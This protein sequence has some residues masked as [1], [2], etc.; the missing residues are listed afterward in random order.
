MASKH[1]ATVLRQRLRTARV[2]TFDA[3]NTLYKL[4]RGVG[5]LYRD[6]ATAHGIDA[7]LLPSAED[8]KESFKESLKLQRARY[9]N[10]F[11]K[12]VDLGTGASGRQIDATG[13]E[14]E[15]EYIPE[16]WWRM[17]LER[18][19]DGAFYLRD[20][21]TRLTALHGD[22][23]ALI[24][25]LNGEDFFRALYHD[26]FCSDAAWEVLPGAV[27]AVARLARWR[28]RC[29]DGAFDV[30]RVDTHGTETTMRS[31]SS[32]AEAEA[33][34]AEFDAKRHKQGYFVRERPARRLGVLSNN[35]ERLPRVLDALGLKQPFDFVLPSVEARAQKPD[36]L[37]F[38]TAWANAGA[39]SGAVAPHEC[40]HIG[41]DEQNDVRGALDAGVQTVVWVHPE[42]VRRVPNRLMAAH[43]Q[44]KLFIVQ[45]LTQLCQV[46]DGDL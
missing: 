25:Q 27:D 39:G 14:W 20:E 21:H 4:R 7:A 46:I 8:L 18:T 3:T 41:D 11:F 26:F 5:E 28:D 6:A 33:V 38:A 24:D 23:D 15:G 12:A 19:W 37:A 29:F 44:Q 10:Y 2:I 35:D 42:G 45:D 13:Y 36:E 30:C 40:V 9:P 17:L 34:V 22:R 43:W 1:V 32:R 31:L 16:E